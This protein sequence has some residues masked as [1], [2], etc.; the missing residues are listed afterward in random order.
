MGIIIVIAWLAVVAVCGLAYRQ[1]W[2]ARSRVGVLW[3]FGTYRPYHA[4]PAASADQEL[5]DWAGSIV[6]VDVCARC[7]APMAA[8]KCPRCHWERPADRAPW[9]RLTDADRAAM[10]AG[11]DIARAIAAEP[12]PGAVLMPAPT[13]HISGAGRDAE[14]AAGAWRPAY[15]GLAPPE[16]PEPPAPP[17][18]PPGG[19]KVPPP[20]PELPP[21]G[22][23]APGTGPPSDDDE[24]DQDGPGGGPWAPAGY[25][26]GAMRWAP[27]RRATPED[28]E[29]AADL[30]RQ[31]ADAAEFIDAMA[32]ERRRYLWQVRR[33]FLAQRGLAF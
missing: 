30:A 14:P 31:D 23:W 26:R 22:D 2:R 17:Q 24:P 1:P 29:H 15:A 32:A 33:G 28:A 4:A 8:G 12:R 9:P 18:P 21:S 13:D 20:E 3:L 25:A 7:A 5:A 10:A 16:P 19:G 27:S 11:L 6:G